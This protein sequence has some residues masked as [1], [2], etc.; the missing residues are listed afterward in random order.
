MKD[1]LV[2]RVANLQKSF[3]KGPQVIEVLRGVDLDV[4]RSEGIAIVGASG[5][6]KS[7]MLHLL[8][9]LEKP[10]S[11]KISYGTND[12]SSMKDQE[13]AR[14]RNTKIGFVFQF[15]YLLP[16]FS[17]L[18]NVMIPALLSSDKPQGARGHAEDLLD[19]V[20]LKDRRTHKPGELSGG[21]QQRV[22]IARS[23]MMSPGILLADEPTG[24]LDSDTGNKIIELFTDLRTR[25]KVTLII[26]THNMDLARTMDRVLVLKGGHLEPTA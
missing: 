20:G 22:A 16:E 13:I 23:L 5:S 17:A 21:E 19:L 7:T 10:D 2:L 18:E 6:G 1:E 4:Y 11:G 9:G 26:A 8:G 24:D 12:I 3:R 15:H 25:L 14:F